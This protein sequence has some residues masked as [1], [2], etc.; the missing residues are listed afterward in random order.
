ML[1][2]EIPSTQNGGLS[3]DGTTVTWKLKKDVT[4]HDGKPFSAD[5]VVFTWEYA[6]DP[7]TSATTIGSYKDVKVEKVDSHTVRVR[8]PKATPFWA[9]AFV[10]TAGMM[11]PKHL[12]G[13]T[14][15]P[16]RAMRPPT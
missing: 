4:W 1:A 9:D 6:A 10:G 2:A 5:D 8:F 7:A 16:S 14:R 11:M 12:F 15:A 3:A 13:P